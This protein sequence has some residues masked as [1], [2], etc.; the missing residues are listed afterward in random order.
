MRL[1]EDAQRARADPPRHSDGALHL[2]RMMRVVGV[3]QEG[4]WVLGCL[5]VWGR[6][7]RG[8]GVWVLGCLGVWN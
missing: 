8:E 5:G 3:N 1:E 2:G 6:R 4:V 7:G